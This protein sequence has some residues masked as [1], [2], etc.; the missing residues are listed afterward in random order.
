MGC[1]K[2]DGPIGRRKDSSFG[3]MIKSK[4]RYSQTAKAIEKIKKGIDCPEFKEVCTK[5]ILPNSTV[6]TLCKDNPEFAFLTGFELGIFRCGEILAK[7]QNDD[8]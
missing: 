4:F 5:P 3:I 7:A 8:K 6:G 2:C 1:K